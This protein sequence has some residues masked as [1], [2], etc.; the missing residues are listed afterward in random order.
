[1]LETVTLICIKMMV[2]MKQLICTLCIWRVPSY[3]K[4][5]ENAVSYIHRRSL[6]CAC[7]VCSRTIRTV[8]YSEG[9]FML[10]VLRNK[11]TYTLGYSD[12][13]S[14]QCLRYFWI[15]K[16]FLR[17]SQK[18][19]FCVQKFE[20]GPSERW[21]FFLEIGHIEHNKIENFMLISKV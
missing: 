17:L 8:G 5:L 20:N 15:G 11:N 19:G 16:V 9:T 6:L 3:H 4:K 7:T 21:I 2:F 14:W 18:R 1:M 13:S 10:L 12:F